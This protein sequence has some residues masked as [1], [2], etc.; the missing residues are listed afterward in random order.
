MALDQEGGPVERFRPGVARL[1]AP[2]PYAALARA[3]GQPAAAREVWQDAAH[4]S[5]L[6]AGFGINLNL[7]PV[8]EP[9]TQAN[10]EFLGERSYGAD[11]DF[12]AGACYNFI[13]GMESAGVGCVIKHFPGEGPGDPH[14]EKMTLSGSREDI[15]QDAAPFL[16]LIKEGRADAVMVSHALVPALDPD[17]IASLSPA[18]LHDWLRTDLKFNGLILADDFS[19]KGAGAADPVAAAVES[20][21]AGTDMVM[22]WPKDVLRLHRALLAALKDGRLSRKRLLD[23][24]SHVLALKLKL[25]IIK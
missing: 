24:A 13:G 22:A 19:M 18:I 16:T 6:L 25:G 17:H 8:A 9:L 3:R 10:R 7:A 2:G 20:V 14:T 15:E 21:T 5:A 12:V 11:S 1:P 4:N 23:A